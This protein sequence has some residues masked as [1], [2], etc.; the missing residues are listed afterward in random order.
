LSSSHNPVL[1]ALQSAKTS[2]DVKQLLDSYGTANCNNAW[3][4]LS[5]LERASLL[6]A[7]EFNGTIIHD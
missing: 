6:L 5:A 2:K 4:Q 1:A 7:K 3:K